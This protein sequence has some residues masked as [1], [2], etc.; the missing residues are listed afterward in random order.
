MI[1]K[2]IIYC[3]LVLYISCIGAHILLFF[4]E[5]IIPKTKKEF[6]LKFIPLSG[7]YHFI[8]SIVF[9]YKKLPKEVK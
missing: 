6:W 1:I 4:T 9:N 3:Y 7:T 2:I 5:E 8:A